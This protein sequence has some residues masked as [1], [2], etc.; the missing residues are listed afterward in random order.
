MWQ[1]SKRR[2]NG[3]ETHTLSVCFSYGERLDGSFWRLVCRTAPLGE[4]VCLCG[5]ADP[6]AN[7]IL[8]GRRQYRYRS[9]GYDC[10]DCF[11]VEQEIEEAIPVGNSVPLAF[12]QPVQHV[13]V[14]V[15]LSAVAE[16][17]HGW[18]VARDPL[19]KSIH[20]CHFLRDW[21]LSEE[22]GR[23]FRVL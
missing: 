22:A 19:T 14:E 5:L 7:L 16:L 18:A 12:S 6:E 2:C 13:V 15:N 17:D 9:D 23:H 10:F 1:D 8:L 11:R 21:H 20:L 3:A 4:V